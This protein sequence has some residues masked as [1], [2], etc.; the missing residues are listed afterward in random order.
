VAGRRGIIAAAGLL[1]RRSESDARSR[2]DSDIGPVTDARADR[3]GHSGADARLDARL[4]AVAIA[5][6]DTHADVGADTRRIGGPVDPGRDADGR[7]LA[8]RCPGG[9][10]DLDRR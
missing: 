10:T 9:P 2:A 1:A 3:H 6:R 7:S 4:D 8:R 5:R